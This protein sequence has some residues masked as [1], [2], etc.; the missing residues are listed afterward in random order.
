M[1]KIKKNQVPRVPTAGR[2]SQSA[3]LRPRGNAVI[4]NSNPL[5]VGDVVD[6]D[7]GGRGEVVSI[8]GTDA[9][10]LFEY[11]IG[12]GKSDPKGKVTVN[13]SGTNAI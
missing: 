9:T 8:K 6:F 5:Q 11:G 2:L 10:I 7:G 1:S 4:S 12:G 3:N 13:V